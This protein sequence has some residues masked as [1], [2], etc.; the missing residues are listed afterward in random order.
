M[1][2]KAMAETTLA[3]PF[4]DGAVLQRER[5]VDIWGTDSPGTTVTINLNAQ[6]AQAVA[7]ENGRWHALMQTGEAGGPY[8]LQVKGSSTVQAANVMIGEVWLAGGQSN[9]EWNVG[10]S[11]DPEA[12]RAAAGEQNVRLLKT[13]EGDGVTTRP[14]EIAG[15][16][17]I[18]E[19]SSVAYHFARNLSKELNITVGIIQTFVSGKAIETFMHPDLIERE[20]PY[21]RRS[22]DYLQT[23]TNEEKKYRQQEPN[24][25][26]TERLAPV[27]P[28][29]IRGFIWWQGEANSGHPLRY[30]AL[31]PAL[32]VDWR[33][34]F[35]VHDAPFYFVEL[36]NAWGIQ[37]TVQDASWPAFREA[38]RHAAEVLDDVWAVNAI[39]VLDEDDK[40]WPD[41]VHPPNKPKVGRRIAHRA[42]TEV[43]GHKA[44][45]WACPRIISVEFKDNKV[46]LD[47]WQAGK[48]LQTTDDEDPRHFF[49][50]G[51][52]RLWVQAK[53]KLKGDRV[54][55]Q[56]EGL[57][58][59]VAARYG[60]ANNPVVNTVNSQGLPLGTW[61]SDDWLLM[62][63]Q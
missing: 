25:L 34:R 30:K 60:W 36:H 37:Q 18:G 1:N 63:N 35:A 47:I 5:K 6:K 33:T 13:A 52:D 26:W 55:L 45:V 4:G 21:Y 43:Y 46:I 56:A 11:R 59:P 12:V 14:W 54:V 48:G 27:V 15:K 3:Y 32:I 42:M 19:W 2:S 62:H 10:R 17:D 29:D 7:D 22:W 51:P 20:F 38:Q 58:N 44:K 40:T 16:D 28:Y 9:M 49:L 53:A 8:T 50:A 24:Y 57:D 31:F 39:D 23:I 61:R 41:E